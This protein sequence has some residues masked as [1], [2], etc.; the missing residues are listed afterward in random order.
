MGRNKNSKIMSIILFTKSI[1]YDDV[2]LIAQPN[3]LLVSRKDVP[4]ELWRIIVS[5]MPAIIGESFAKKAYD[6]GLTVCLHRFCSKEDQLKIYK[7]LNIDDND[8][9]QWARIICSIGL[10]DL[11]RFNY[12]YD[13]GIRAFCIDVANSYL[14]SVV[15]FNRKIFNKLD[16][17]GLLM[18]GNIHSKEGIELYSNFG[19]NFLMRI[20]IGGGQQCE[21][22]SKSTGYGRGQITELKECVE[23]AGDTRI[24]IVADG[25]I[26]NGAYA[27]KAFGI[28][29]Q[30]VMLGTYFSKAEEAQNIID[31]EYKVWGCASDY[32]QLKFGEKRNH[33]E[34]KVSNIDKNE[35][36]PL[37]YL[38]DEL[39]GGISS[40][41]SYGGYNRLSNFIGNGIFELKY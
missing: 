10:N 27:A 22:S 28:G 5:P 12:L 8:K 21:T 26:K 38:V 34:G 36:K 17:Q 9:S 15:D 40:A 6:L 7:S 16:Y 13:N 32:N 3:N 35:I 37:S 33:S 18:A 4:K 41:V 24:S 11:D 19:P 14:K 2:N 20:G 25:G 30:Y 31:K 39:W 23:M 1:Y 29:S